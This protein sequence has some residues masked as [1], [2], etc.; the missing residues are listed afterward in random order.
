MRAS[1]AANRR[2]GSKQPGIA[3]WQAPQAVRSA[4]GTGSQVLR[5][6]SPSGCKHPPS[7][8]RILPQNKRHIAE[9]YFLLRIP[10]KNIVGRL[11]SSREAAENAAHGASPASSV[12]SGPAS[13]GRKRSHERAT[14][15]KNNSYDA[16]SCTGRDSVF[17][18][19]VRSFGAKEFR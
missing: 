4:R 10:N 14:A 1:R 18:T 7:L 5:R 6:M 3:R 16:S 9:I 15:P 12:E 17:L 13:K 2:T 19:D 8:A 11:M